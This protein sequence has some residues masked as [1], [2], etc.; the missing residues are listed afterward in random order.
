MLV[1]YGA[2]QNEQQQVDPSKDPGLLLQIML[3][4]ESATLDWNQTERQATAA[5]GIPALITGAALPARL[6]GPKI[7]LF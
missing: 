2:Q 3:E 4:S 1:K 5:V 7:L 6:L